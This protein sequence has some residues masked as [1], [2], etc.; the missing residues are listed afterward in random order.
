MKKIILIITTSFLGGC[1]L[2]DALLMKYDPNEYLL[3]S[4][5]RSTAYMSKFTCNDQ[6]QSKE[7]AIS[8]ANKTLAFRQFVEYLPHNNKVISSS[9]DLD[10]IAQSLK[11]QYEKS[12]NVSNTFCKIKFQ[13][14]ETSAENMQKAIGDKPK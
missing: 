14:I 10:E 2:A 7:R 13:S 3:I 5:I 1:T 4:N 12:N 8:I 6:K 9:K 11:N